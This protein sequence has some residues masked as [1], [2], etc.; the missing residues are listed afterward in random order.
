[1]AIDFKNID[2]RSLGK[3]VMDP[4]AAKDLNIFLEKVPDQ[5][6]NAVLVAAGIAWACA[7]AAGLFTTIKV[8]E[9]TEFRTQVKEAEALVPIVPKISDKA[10]DKA[11]VEAFVKEA[12]NIYKGLTFRADGSTVLISATSTSRFGEFRE[13]IG[14]VQNGGSGWR[15]SLEKLCVGRE[16]DR[17]RVLSASLKIN[18]V[19]VENPS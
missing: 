16:C 2:W 8:Q 14:H 3:K 11:S 4:N 13:A 12:S 15:V 7:A 18:K 5:A 1:M 10:I 6:G 9:L 19:S 17:S